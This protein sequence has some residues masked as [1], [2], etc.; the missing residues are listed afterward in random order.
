[1][2]PKLRYGPQSQARDSS[3]PRLASSTTLSM[4]EDP[5][6]SRVGSR[7][8]ARTSQTSGLTQYQYLGTY[9]GFFN[10]RRQ[11]SGGISFLVQ[12]RS[13]SGLRSDCPSL[14]KN[15]SPSKGPGLR[16]TRVFLS[17]VRPLQGGPIRC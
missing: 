1:M 5:R 14:Y 7:K 4:E 9:P 12:I 11:T 8:Y 16:K 17:C 15:P 6:P 3:G 2:T 13:R 10:F